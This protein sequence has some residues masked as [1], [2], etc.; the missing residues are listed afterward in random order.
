MA[1]LPSYVTYL[2]QAARDL[3]GAKLFRVVRVLRILKLVRHSDGMMVIS[4]TARACSDE[5]GLLLFCLLVSSIV[6]SS[7]VF[8]AESQVVPQGRNPAFLSIPHTMWWAVVT[9]TTIGYGDLYPSTGLGQLFGVICALSGVVMVAVPISVISMRFSFKFAEHNKRIQVREQRRRRTE[10]IQESV[11]SVL[12]VRRADSTLPISIGSLFRVLSQ[13]MLWF[14][15]W[16]ASLR[17]RT[18]GR[19][20][21]TSRAAGDSAPAAE[22]SA[23][24]RSRGGAS[25]ACKFSMGNKPRNSGMFTEVRT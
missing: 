7:L 25:S 23:R 4:K 20:S 17:G 16:T 19:T 21:S 9:M 12:G 2:V 6:F 14:K 8:Y 18:A 3:S 15:K 13:R 10:K 1:I 24:R 11:R 22:S 5:L